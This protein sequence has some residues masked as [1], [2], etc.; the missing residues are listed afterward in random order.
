MLC[1][2][3]FHVNKFPGNGIVLSS[4]FK[5]TALFL[6]KIIEDRH[7]A[8]SQSKILIV[9]EAVVTN[10]PQVKIQPQI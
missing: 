7:N 4:L 2:I 6:K 3:C 10:F 8:A 5:N 9:S 1:I